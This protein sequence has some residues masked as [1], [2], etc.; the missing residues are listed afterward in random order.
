MVSHE[1]SELYD[2]DIVLLIVFTESG[3]QQH[4]AHHVCLMFIMI[5]SLLMI[6][7]TEIFEKSF[8]TNHFCKAL[9]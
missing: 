2:K 3:L 6:D 4:H 5:L 7:I 1:C 9:S 8:W